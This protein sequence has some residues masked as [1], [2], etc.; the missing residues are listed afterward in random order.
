MRM[1]MRMRGGCRFWLRVL[2]HQGLL[3]V[4]VGNG[5]HGLDTGR[6]TMC[7]PM[8]G[9][10]RRQT[11]PRFIRADHGIGQSHLDC[12][13]PKEAGGLGGAHRFGCQGAHARDMIDKQAI[14]TIDFGL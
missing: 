10:Q 2:R 12:I 14:Q 6:L 9:P 5:C 13:R 11:R 8:V 3:G 4:G 7:G 1:W